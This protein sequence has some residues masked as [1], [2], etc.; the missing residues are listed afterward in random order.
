M[1]KALQRGG[2]KKSMQTGVN[3]KITST[4]IRTSRNHIV[5]YLPKIKHNTFKSMHTKE[6]YSPKISNLNEV[7][8]DLMVLLILKQRSYD[9]NNRD[10]IEA[11]HLY[12]GELCISLLVWIPESVCVCLWI[13]CSLLLH[14]H[15]SKDFTYW[16]CLIV[17][18]FLLWPY[19]KCWFKCLLVEK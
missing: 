14:H 7:L 4:I 19:Y 1:K 9:P 17:W 5:L 10:W 13:Q 3:G 2:G 11:R 6:K 18:T 16:H 8:S 12:V 15:I